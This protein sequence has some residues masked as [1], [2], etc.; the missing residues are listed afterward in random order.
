M[1]GPSGGTEASSSIMWP[2]RD[3][4]Y[5]T[6][7]TFCNQ[8]FHY[9]LTVSIA[10]FQESLGR[11]KQA[12]L[13]LLFSCGVCARSR[14]F[15]RS[16]KGLS[17]AEFERKNYP[18]ANYLHPTQPERADGTIYNLNILG[19]PSVNGRGRIFCDQPWALMFSED[20]LNGAFQGLVG[21]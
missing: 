16:E 13:S 9:A 10:G 15:G 8:P 20:V 5:I 2:L 4:Y 3:N 11:S 17:A 12:P 21:N 7:Q 18:D 19:M 14:R 6:H 1:N